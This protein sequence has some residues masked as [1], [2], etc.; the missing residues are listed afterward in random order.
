MRRLV[1]VAGLFAIWSYSLGY[2]WAQAG[3]LNADTAV[4]DSNVNISYYTLGLHAC[5][6]K[7]DTIE[8]SFILTI[9]NDTDKDWVYK[10]ISWLQSKLIDNFGIEHQQTRGYFENGRCESQESL[11]LTK[12]DK[13]WIV[14][15]FGEAKDDIT[16]ARIVFP[17]P[18]GA[19]VLLNGPVRNGG[20]PTAVQQK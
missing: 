16:Q 11:N 20:L 8:C 13:A 7:G 17:N 19:P 4:T 3:C 6:N 5:V 10:N 15:D 14:Q 12:G 9:D 1:F 2:G 18:W